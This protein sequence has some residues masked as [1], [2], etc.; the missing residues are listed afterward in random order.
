MVYPILKSIE[1]RG[2]DS[3]RFCRDASFDVGR[4]GDPEVRIDVAELERLMLA[5]AAFTEDA[6]FGLHQGLHTEAAD[7]G[8]L[9]Y[10]MMHSGTVGEALKAYRRYNDILCSGFNLEWEARG[11]D[12]RLRFVMLEANG[13]MSR[14]C[15]E[16]MASSVYRLMCGMSNRRFPLQE[17]T[18]R[19]AAPGGTAP[20]L[21]VFGR[22]PRFDGDENAIRFH[23]DVMALPIL[24][25]DARLRHMFESIA[26]RT[27]E[28]LSNGRTLSDAVFRRMLERMPA[29]FPTL[30]E[31]AAS[32][33][34][35]A[36]S[37][38]L[39][40]K[41]EG[42]SYNELAAAVRKELAEG[43]LRQPEHSVGD[44]AYLLRFSEP[45]AFQN[46]FKKWT[47][48]TPGQY[49]AR[50]RAAEGSGSGTPPGAAA[51]R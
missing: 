32:F 12:I 21:S 31:T 45:S 26:A 30:Q 9:G 24:Y 25:A 47:G 5:G 44:V 16:D 8:V 38:Q 49:R 1:Q 10:V 18:F 2:F 4:L 11:D 13:R 34:M 23:K 14:H 36:R 35:S 46:A 28:T 40:L 50:L 19:H 3:E 37:F 17:V 51:R 27:L 48:L 20:Y 22:A 15:V 41:E 6:Y 29:S 7:L 42:T 43:Y 33:H 39:K